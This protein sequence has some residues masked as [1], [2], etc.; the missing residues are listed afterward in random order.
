MKFKIGNKVKVQNV[1]DNY[2]IDKLTGSVG[3]VFEIVKDPY[4]DKTGPGLIYGVKFKN[5]LGWVGYGGLKP[6][7]S[8]WF[9]HP[10]DLKLIRRAKKKVKK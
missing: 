1:T 3:T 7:Y 9:I 4:L 8:G 2:G 5:S 10:S 6:G